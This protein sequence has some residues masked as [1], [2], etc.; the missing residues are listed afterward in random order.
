MDPLYSLSGFAVGIIVGLTGVGGGSLMTPLL[1][2]VFGIHP[3]TAV[4]TDLLYAAL[5]KAGGT[6]IHRNKGN[7]D[8]KITG[9]LAAG[10]IPAALI[11]LA[12]L[13]QLPARSPQV[14]HLISFS[15]GT[16]LLLTALAIVFRARIIN[17]SL[18]HENA[19]YRRH[20]GATTV[21][22]GALL[23]MMVTISSVGAGALG[24]AALFF[25][26]PRLPA[27]R[28]VGS[29]I[30]HAV[31][32]TL[33]AGIGHWILGS[34]DWILLGSLLLGSLPGIWLGTQISSRIPDRVLRPLLASMLVLIGAKLIA[35]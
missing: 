23:G 25:L 2:L 7:V 1:V 12:L 4:G 11:T 17:W 21:A 32:L 13:S 30:A 10:S 5:T 33:V 20:L 27:V 34:V 14:T 8:W 15:L 28:I 3:A 9:L 6:L 24:V 35:Q 22:V 16:A 19:F 18:R 29:D 31:P 26:Y